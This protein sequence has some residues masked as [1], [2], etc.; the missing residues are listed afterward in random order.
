VA[1]IRLTVLR[2]HSVE[3]P[4]VES[5]IVYLIEEEKAYRLREDGEH[6]EAFEVPVRFNTGARIEATFPKRAEAITFLRSFV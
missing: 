1:A 2:G 5:A 3:C 4:D 6:R